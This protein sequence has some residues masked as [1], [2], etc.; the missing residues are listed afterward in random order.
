[1]RGNV[2]CHNLRGNNLSSATSFDMTFSGLAD[3]G[4]RRRCLKW[5]DWG[6]AKPHDLWQP[7]GGG[8]LKSLVN[9]QRM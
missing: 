2:A 7:D 3:F 9:R 4:A 6:A 8:I 5:H 1:M